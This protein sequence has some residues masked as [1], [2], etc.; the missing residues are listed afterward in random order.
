[1][2]KVWLIAIAAIMVLAVVVDFF[3]KRAGLKNI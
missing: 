2:E 3:L 1:V